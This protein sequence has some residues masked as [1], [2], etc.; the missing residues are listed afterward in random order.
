MSEV[1]TWREN[2]RIIRLQDSEPMNRINF[3]LESPFSSLLPFPSPSV[4]SH[5]SLSH[6]SPFLSTFFP[7]F[8]PVSPLFSLSGALP[9]KPARGSGERC[10]LHSGY[11][12]SPA[13][14][15]FLVFSVMSGDS[16]VEEVYT[17]QTV[18]VTRW[19]KLLECPDTHDTHGGC[20]IAN[21]SLFQGDS[22]CQSPAPNTSRVMRP[23]AP[24]WRRKKNKWRDYFVTLNNKSI[25]R[26]RGNCE[27]IATWGSPCHASPF[28]F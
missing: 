28:S 12:Q 8:L 15:R 22:Q 24:L 9:S 1:E 3:H 2:A 23:I 21:E 14:K 7:P 11:R 19:T 25:T 4:S 10:E 17:L 18:Q 20:A 5:L 27:C 16:G 13:S 26:K 6:P